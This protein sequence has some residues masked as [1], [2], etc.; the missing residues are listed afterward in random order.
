M[1]DTPSFLFLGRDIRLP[2]DLLIE[3]TLPGVSEQ[4]TEVMQAR[5]TAAA[6]RE[7][8]R[9]VQEAQ[10]ARAR[11]YEKQHRLVNPRYLQPKVYDIDDLVFVRQG[12]ETVDPRISKYSPLAI[13]PYRVLKRFN[14][15][16]SY[17]LQLVADPNPANNRKVHVS[18]LI[19]YTADI[20]HY[21]QWLNSPAVNQQR[22]QLDT[23]T[24][25]RLPSPL[26]PTER[27]NLTQLAN[28]QSAW[29]SD[30]NNSYRMMSL[31]MPSVPYNR[32]RSELWARFHHG[33]V[34]ADRPDSGIPSPEEVI[35]MTTE[36]IARLPSRAVT[37]QRLQQ[38]QDP[39]YVPTSMAE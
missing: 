18:R 21:L 31:A 8:Y 16:V 23:T 4:R 38:S 7:S 29:D 12:S 2:I 19:P 35:H 10:L 20:Q 36:Q 14:E 17:E 6:L 1:K 13:G 24:A 15:N 11:I 5:E 32:E 37:R 30:P 39:R 9:T 34:G 22:R 28:A 3:D 27:S 26:T 25:N 33:P